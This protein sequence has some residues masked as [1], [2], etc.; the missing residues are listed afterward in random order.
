MPTSSIDYHKALLVPSPDCPTQ[1]LCRTQDLSALVGPWTTASLPGTKLATVDIWTAM[2]NTTLSIPMNRYRFFRSDSRFE[3]RC[4]A[5]SYFYGSLKMVWSPREYPTTWD[6][7]GFVGVVTQFSN[8]PGVRAEANGDGVALNVPYFSQYPCV[9]QRVNGPGSLGFITIIVFSRL[10]CID[11]SS[12]A[13]PVSISLLANFVDPVVD[14][15]L[16]V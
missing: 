14:G 16:A 13:A 4:Q 3:L 12:S 6:S 8:I 1:L 7:S 10:C 2:H 5:N 11:S 9:D 15:P